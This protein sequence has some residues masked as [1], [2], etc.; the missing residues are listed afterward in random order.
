[1]HIAREKAMAS[2]KSKMV[3]LVKAIATYSEGELAEAAD[4]LDD[5]ER[6]KL[7]T[8]SEKFHKH[9]KV[10]NTD[11]IGGSNQLKKNSNRVTMEQKFTTTITKIQKALL[12]YESSDLIDEWNI[13]FRAGVNYETI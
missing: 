9:L 5:D 11:N 4:E 10:V 1:V 12:T 6:R 3:K 7:S 13:E 2:S 8:L